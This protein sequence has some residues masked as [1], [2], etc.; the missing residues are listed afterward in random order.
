M[1]HGF[2]T[3]RAAKVFLAASALVA[4]AVAAVIIALPAAAATA[5]PQCYGLERLQPRVFVEAALPQQVREHVGEILSQ[6]RLWVRDFYGHTDSDP[7][8][9]ICASQSCD[10]RIAAAARAGNPTTTRF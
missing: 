7:R 5:C 4:V 3:H 2:L 9:L 10:Q 1:R 6:A 8:I